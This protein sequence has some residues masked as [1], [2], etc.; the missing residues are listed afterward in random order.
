MP[1]LRRKTNNK[2]ILK[3]FI[4]VATYKDQDSTPRPKLVT[5]KIARKN[6]K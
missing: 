5:G 6:I 4:K 1:V 3:Y 2:Y